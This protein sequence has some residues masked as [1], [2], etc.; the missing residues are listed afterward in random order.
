VNNVHTFLSKLTVNRSF[1]YDFVDANAPC[2]AL[3]L[4][5][6]R[7]QQCGLLALRP[8]ELIPPAVSN[9]GFNFGH[10]LFGNDDF[11][12]IHFAFQFYG[13][14]TYNVLLNP[15][16]P[17]VQAV[18]RRMVETGEY[19]FFALSPEQSVTAFRTEIGKQVLV[20]LK[21]HLRRILAS[22]TTDAQ[23]Q[24]ALTQFR[25]SMAPTDRL[26]NW[27][28]RD[29]RAS[30]DLNHDRLEL[31]PSAETNEK[32]PPR[33]PSKAQ[34]KPEPIRHPLSMLPTI[35]M[36]IDGELESAEELR[37]SLSAARKRPYLLDDDTV[38]R[39]FRLHADQLEFVPI[40]REQLARWRAASPAPAQR[41]EIERLSKQLDRHEDVLAAL[42]ALARELE[43]GTV[44]AIARMDEGELGLAM[45]DGTL[46]PPDGAPVSEGLRLQ[47][48]HAIA[49][50]LDAYLEDLEENGFNDLDILGQMAPQMP[51]LKRLME[52]SNEGDMADLCDEFFALDRFVRQL[53]RLAAG[54][55][56]G[57]IEV[58]S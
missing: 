46:S 15:S 28:C 1:M 2:F 23:Y 55:R 9:V 51:L 37:T 10:S 33:R 29:N 20:G 8:G 54:I 4:V 22:S 41:A 35:A 32:P 47:E 43:S 36:L 24:R 39:V 52:I 26:L 19:F 6:E 16:N 40:N 56:S 42:V 30:L 27:A 58:P 14:R 18:V 17:I 13:F 7:K 49:K 11:E 38:Q 45:F 34:S 3:G 12:V 25:Q 57:A 50:V 21:M 44:E 53:E 48:Q 5:E 31:N